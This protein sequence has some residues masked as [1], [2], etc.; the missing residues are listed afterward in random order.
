MSGGDDDLV[1][2]LRGTLRGHGDFDGAVAFSEDDAGTGS[3]L[4]LGRVGLRVGLVRPE[5][6]GVDRGRR[7][8]LAES[9][10]KEEGASQKHDSDN[11]D[12]FHGISLFGSLK[13][14]IRRAGRAT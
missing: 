5:H 9:H 11:E 2:D 12:S 8:D 4:D 3:R 14:V 7:E 10:S 6:E 13:A 1:T